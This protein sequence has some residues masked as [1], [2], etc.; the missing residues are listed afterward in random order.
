MSGN[1]ECQSNRVNGNCVLCCVALVVRVLSHSFPN[2][3]RRAAEIKQQQALRQTVA[4][5]QQKQA[6]V[7]DVRNPGRLP[8]TEKGGGNA[9]QNT[10]RHVPCKCSF[11]QA[12]RKGKRRRRERGG[13]DSIAGRGKQYA[14]IR[15]NDKLRGNE[16]W[17]Q[18]SV[19]VCVL[20]PA[21]LKP[22]DER[23]KKRRKRR[24]LRTVFCRCLYI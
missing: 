9:K 6:V 18:C 15:L 19:A 7:D 12:R 22:R 21:Q 14:T 23:N 20:L 5:W 2:R 11:T 3:R 4:N 16:S 13:R 10:T 8:T 1:Y 24:Q 17:W